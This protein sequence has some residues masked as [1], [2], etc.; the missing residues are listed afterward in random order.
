MMGTSGE[1][2]LIPLTYIHIACYSEFILARGLNFPVHY[3][4]RE[5]SQ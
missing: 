1:Y 5:T 3:F 2:R 4:Y